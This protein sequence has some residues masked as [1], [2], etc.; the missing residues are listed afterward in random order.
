MLYLVLAHDARD[1]DA[2]ERRRRVR[3]EHLGA[4]RPWIDTG[5]LQVAGAY[6]DEDGEMRGSMMIVEADDEASL[7]AKLDADVYVREGV[8]ER[9]EIHP[10]ARAV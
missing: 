9:I 4:L 6:L 10:F 5:R 1:P 7:R 8:W 3:E 2:P